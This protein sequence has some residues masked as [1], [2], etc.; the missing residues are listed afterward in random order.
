MHFLTLDP[1]VI[2]Q[3]LGYVGLF[4]IVLAESGLFFGFFLPGDSLLFTAGLLASQGV[5]NV[6]ALLIITPVA[7]VAGN[8]IG[9][10]FGAWVGPKLFTKQDSF[11]FS[12]KHI[13]RSQQ[14]YA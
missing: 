12:T 5:L 1:I 10:W 2:L 8:S 6:W 4:S 3:T 13:E 9:Y 7:A 14:F 11:F